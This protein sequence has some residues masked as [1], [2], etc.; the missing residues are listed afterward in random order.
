[1]SR[2]LMRRALWATLLALAL[3]LW[4][5]PQWTAPS[6][7][8][9][10]A[11]S[12]SSSPPSKERVER[13]RYLAQIGN[14]AFCHTARGGE[15]YGGGRPI[16]TPFG[17]VYSSNLTPDK[18]Q[19]IGQWS[20]DEFWRAMHHG[21]S[22]DNRLLYP[23]FPYTSYTR[24]TREDSDALWAYLQTVPASAR[25]NQEPALAWPTNTQAA[26]W[27]WRTLYFRAGENGRAASA[28]STNAQ[29]WARGAYLTEGLGHCFECHSRRNALGAIE[30]IGQGNLLPG[31]RWYAPSLLDRSEGS[32]ADWT[33][34]QVVEFLTRGVSSAGQAAGP[35]AEVVLHGTQH[36]NEADARAM[37]AYL[38]GLPAVRSL[39]ASADPTASA[40]KTGG[41]AHPGTGAMALGTQLRLGAALYKKHCAECHGDQGEGVATIY[42]ALAGN[43]AVNMDPP[44]NLVQAVLHGGFAPA[45]ASNP[46]PYGMPPFMLSFNDTE[47]AAVLT[48][49]RHEWGNTGSALGEFD[50]TRIRQ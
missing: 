33:T 23:A 36:L 7:P 39:P 40:P 25:A 44:H 49:V 42:P 3:L 26:L 29:Q 16:D 38:R 20:A 2:R 8:S 11:P 48:Y 14:C 46:R 27:A 32:V 35:M 9:P 12:P 15:V 4:K 22:R 24:I 28:P 1:M 21:V 50:I 5:G 19:G 17:A 34:D 13:G 31:S 47:I 37:A 6:V 30:S 18:I 41:T 45:T 10:T 43:R